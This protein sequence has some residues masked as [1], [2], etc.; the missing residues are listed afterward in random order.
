MTALPWFKFYPADWRS[1]P[2]LRAVSPAARG[3][4]IEML[5]LMHEAEPRG[6]LL[7]NGRPVTDAQLSALAGVPLDIA[8]A[9]LGELESAGTFSRTRAGVIYSRRMRADTGKSAKQK[10]NVDKRW[11]KHRETGGAQRTETTHENGSGNT[12]LDTKP[13]P[14][15]P[16]ARGQKGVGS[17]SALPDDP[18]TA[19]NDWN[20]LADRLGLPRAKDLTP[21]RRAKLKT[22]LAHGGLAE[23]RDALRAVETSRFCRGLKS[24]FK[25]DL[26]FVLQDRSYQRLIEGFYGNDVAP[27]ASAVPAVPPTPEITASRLRR[28]ADTGEWAESWGPKPEERAA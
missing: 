8:Q 13:I 19:F 16:E 7:L 20:A 15:K 27:K 17:A 24:D 6:H 11:Q 21:A 12:E 3:L 5:C 22:R 25:A 10:A 9:L 26:D 14:K 1:E 18:L 4:W 2:S 28:F 23:W